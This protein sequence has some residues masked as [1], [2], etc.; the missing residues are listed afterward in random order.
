MD[1][2]PV[3]AVNFDSVKSGFYR[4][5]RRLA[6]RMDKVLN[7][8]LSQ[9]PRHRCIRLIRSDSAGADCWFYTFGSE[10]AELQDCFC[11]MFL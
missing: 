3:C 7:V 1:E 2:K 8:L 6:E 11:S 4:S 5:S 9:C 10:M